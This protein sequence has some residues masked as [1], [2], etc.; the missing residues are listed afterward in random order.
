VQAVLVYPLQS[1]QL[2]ARVLTP[3]PQVALHADHEP[4]TYDEA[5]VPEP[6]TTTAG[7]ADDP[8]T[9]PPQPKHTNA[10][11]GISVA[12]EETKGVKKLPNV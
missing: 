2:T 9:Q 8:E 3:E 1:R 6:E 7:G 4:L 10:V 12:H 5:H 11:L